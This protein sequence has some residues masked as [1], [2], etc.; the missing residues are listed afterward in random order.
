VL[1]SHSLR[2]GPRTVRVANLLLD[3]S[4]WAYAPQPASKPVLPVGIPS[5]DSN[6]QNRSLATKPC[7]IEKGEDCFT[8]LGVTWSD[9]GWVEKALVLSAFPAFLL[10]AAVVRGLAV[11]GVSEVLSFAFSAPVLIVVWVYVIGW[12]IDRWQYKRFLRR[13]LN[14]S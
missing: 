14:K 13:K 10:D 11:L 12:L 4:E 1:E 6:P 3:S 5:L 7:E 9:P 8:D 2:L